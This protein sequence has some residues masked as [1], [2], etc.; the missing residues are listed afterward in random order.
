METRQLPRSVVRITLLEKD[1]AGLTVPRTLYKKNRTRKKGSTA[2]RPAEKAMRRAM[3]A[4]GAWA[5]R[6][7]TAHERSNEKTRDGWL[8]DLPSNMAKAVKSGTR[9]LKFTRPIYP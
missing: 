5:D 3:K 2:A 6:Y 4:A 8:S 7:T 1:E 9:Q